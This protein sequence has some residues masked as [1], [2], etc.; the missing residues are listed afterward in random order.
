MKLSSFLVYF[1]MIIRNAKLPHFRSQKPEVRSQELEAGIRQERCLDLNLDLRSGRIVLLLGDSGSGKSTLM[2]C[3]AGFKELEA[4]EIDLQN[5]RVAMLLQNPFHQIIMQKAHDELLFPMKNAGM[6]DD[7]ALAE[8]NKVATMLKIEHLLDRNMNTLLFGETQL[9]M[10]AATV[11]TPADIYLFD[12]PTSHLDP[13]FIRLFYGVLRYLAGQG[14]TVLSSS[15]NIDEFVFVDRILSL[16]NGCL[17]SDLT[18]AEMTAKVQTGE[19]KTDKQLIR[20]K[21]EELKRK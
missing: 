13:P 17:K 18:K 19:I 16:E 3:I 20:Q 1:L 11:L 21:L 7:A 9:L 8:L 4:G 15:Q 14:K 12:E 5:Q 10:I 6:P 2:R